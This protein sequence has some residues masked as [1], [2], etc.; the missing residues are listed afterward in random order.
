MKDYVSD[1]EFAKINDHKAHT[2]IH[3]TDMDKFV[4]SLESDEAKVRQKK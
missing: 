1:Y 2:L 3:I 4:A